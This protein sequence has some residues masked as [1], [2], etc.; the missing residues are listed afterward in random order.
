M[1]PR[2]SRRTLIPLLV[3]LH[4]TVMLWGPCLHALP[5]W[6]HE[7]FGNRST[8][9]GPHGDPGKA[10]HGSAHDCPV[11]HFLLQGQLP[12]ESAREPVL[13]WAGSLA[14]IARPEITSRSRHRSSC[15]RAPPAT[16]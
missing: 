1:M 7:A 2:L 3:A 4:A 5:G 13:R 9:D 8:G 14:L 6:G 16:C 11:C 15:P 12:V 10:P